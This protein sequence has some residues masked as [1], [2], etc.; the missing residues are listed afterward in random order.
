[1]SASFSRRDF[2]KSAIV[3][4]GALAGLTAGDAG[5]FP[6]RAA[7]RIKRGGIWRA[8]Q[9]HTPPTLDAQRISMY[10]ASIG[11]MYDC[12]LSIKTNPKTYAQEI[13]PGL[14]SEWQVE[15]KGRRVV[16]VLRKG[17]RFHDGSRFDAQA[18]K[19]NL[20]RVRT[21]P[22]SYLKAD[23]GE[24]E[25]V[26][27]L[28]D[29]SIAVNLKYPSGSLLYNLSDGALWSGMVSKAFQ[30]K[31]GDDELARKGCGTGPFRCKEWIVDQKI[32]LERFPDY[33][34]AGADGKPLPYLDGFEE[35]YRPKIDQ[36]VIDLRAGSLDT[37]IDPATRDFPAIKKDSGLEYVEMPPFEWHH[38]GLGFNSRK[39]PFTSHALRKAAC[40]AIDRERIVK[41]L[42]FGVARVH[43]YPWITKGQPG[44]A[45]EAWPDYS[46][47]PS[48]A[49]ELV[50][51]DSPRGV[52]V[53]LLSIAREPDST[54][55]ELLKA[56]WDKA[57]IKTELKSIERLGWIEA[58]RK[59]NF[60]AGFWNAAP[61]MGAFI[62]PKLMTGAPGN[63]SNFKNPKVD[64]MLE[65]H[66][67]TLEPAKQHELMKEILK[68]VYE[69][70]EL[71]CAFAVTQAVG[72][73][74]KVK[75]IRT[76][77]RHIAAGEVWLDI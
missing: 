64:Q 54:Y 72:T 75:G 15:K 38:I 14:A 5:I 68:I 46:F 31:H 65:E 26:E 27:L 23:L 2:L 29:D 33:W 52:T 19:W 39:G 7:E 6:A 24:I 50:K 59:D 62:R 73:H 36:A 76:Y 48:K 77:W 10:W 34:R 69:T 4:A 9:A 8:A 3:G 16:F 67:Q 58:M 41:I 53:E 13:V 66:L 18:A 70:A 55:A 61:Y 47:N 40:Y 71:T 74:K 30:E 32:V 60:H 21:H 22:K 11:A 49:A 63:W 37:V 35:H 25:S 20:D 56:M 28:N 43:Q 42:G 12:L 45:P 1:M 44:W 51:A 57:G 17:V